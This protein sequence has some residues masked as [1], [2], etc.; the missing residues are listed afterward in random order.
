MEQAEGARYLGDVGDPSSSDYPR[1]L[2]PANE[3]NIWVCLFYATMCVLFLLKE[4]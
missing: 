1:G 3:A 2:N 4:P